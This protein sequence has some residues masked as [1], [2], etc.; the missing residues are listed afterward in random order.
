MAA[1]SVNELGAGKLVIET[2]WGNPFRRDY[3][4]VT[5]AIV[6]TLTFVIHSLASCSLPI[7]AGLSKLLSG[8]ASKR[9]S[10]RRKKC[11]EH[12]RALATPG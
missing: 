2:H 10:E 6:Y 7:L 12:L 8:R 5:I 11:G 4:H 9:V 3:F 1:T